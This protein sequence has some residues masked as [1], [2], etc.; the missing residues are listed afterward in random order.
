MNYY[1]TKRN[2][3]AG[4][5]Y[6][7]IEKKG[8]KVFNFVKAQTRRSPYIR[9]VYFR[10]DKIF[11]KLFWGHLYDK[12]PKDRIRRMKYIDCGFDLIRNS[13]IDPITRENF[14]A[15]NE[16]LHRFY[17]KTKGGETYV[18]QIKENKRT[19]RKDLISIFPG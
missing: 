8:R 13:K 18:V 2:K 16:L 9:S 7:E 6:S 11:I 10:K 5:S 17:G 14:K 4:T 19:K 12:Y 3:I 1:K 15:K